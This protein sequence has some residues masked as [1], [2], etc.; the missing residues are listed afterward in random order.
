M[1]LQALVRV[2]FGEIAPRGKVPVT[3]TQP[4]PSRTVFY[5]YGYGLGPGS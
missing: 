3:I 1:S 4:P 2:L 5:P